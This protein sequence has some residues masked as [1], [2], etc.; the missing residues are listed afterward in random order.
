[1]T[2]ENQTLNSKKLGFISSLIC[3]L[4][5]NPINSYLKTELSGFL[6]N[7]FD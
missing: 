2:L 7:E 1:L 3:G 6:M 4:L 5:E